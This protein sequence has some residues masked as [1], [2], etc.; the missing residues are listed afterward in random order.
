VKNSKHVW[1]GRGLLSRSAVIAV[2]LLAGAVA[3]AQQTTG[4]PCSPAATTTVDGK[5]LPS[6]SPEFG[7]AVNMSY[8]DSKSCWPATVVPPKGAPNILLI[9]TDDQ[10]YGVSSTFG[11]V[12]PTPALDRVAK[13]GLRYTQFHSTA[14]CSPTR[15]ALITGRNHHSVGFGVITEMSTGYPGYDSIIGPESATVAEILKE[16]GY[17]TSWFGKNHNTP[18]MQYSVAGP[19]NQWPSGMGFD[20]FYGFMGGETD[21]WTPWLFQNTTQIFPWVGHPGYNLITDMA[22]EAIKYLKGLNDAAPDKPFFL[23]YVPGGSHAPHQPTPEWIKKISDMHLFNKGWNDVREQILANQKRLGVVPANTQL[24]PWPDG[25]PEFGGAKLAKWETLSPDEKKLFIRQA[26]IFAAYT[27][28]TDHEIGRVIQA[29]DDMG[30]LDNTLIIYIV[31]DNGTSAEG[32]TLGTPFDMAAIQG[33]NIPVADQLKYYD[34]WGSPKT[35]PHMAVGWTWAFDTPFKWT[36]QVASHFG[37]TRQGLAISWP[38][39]ITDVG[40]LRTQFHHVIDIVPTLLEA[41]GIQAPVM[42]NGIAQKP[43]EGVTMAYTFDKANANAP[44]KRTTQYFEMVGNRAIYH[45]GWIAATTPPLAPWFLGLGKFPEVVNG[46]TWEL[47]NLDEDY[48][49][50]NDLAA[51]MPDKLLVMKELF[52]LEAEKYNV[53]PLDNSFT[54]R[55]LAPRPSATAGKTVF[56]YS[57]E[58]SGLPPSDAP[59]I[60]NKSYTITA[61]V[62]IPAG[63]A[64]GML[65]TIGGRFGGYGLYLVKGKPV[66]TYVQLTAEKFR[67]EG[68]AALTPGKHTIAFD[69]KY[70][71]PGFGKGGNGVLSVD[72]KAVASKTIP[73]TIPFVMTI[74]ESFDVGMDTRSGVDDNDYQ[75]PFRFNGKLDKLTIKLIPPE[76]TAAE[77]DLLKRKTQEAINAAQ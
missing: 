4:V 42:V 63:V 48:S 70:D 41:A 73:F 56:T 54:A 17:A 20:Y 69:F 10:G 55:A 24:T 34:D 52:L 65:N 6:P 37:G 1:S 5:Y 75:P 53:F 26:D 50:N 35:T 13:A 71:G 33:I 40:G 57:G 23:C 72:G 19:Y 44:S 66:F 59:N 77:D 2:F 29:V 8:K 31:G 32:S 25:Q 64:E 28:Y 62:E 67:W 46:Y 12:I 3:H 21:Q 61:E 30:K 14:L 39:H 27:A 38:G 76:R 18:S 16:N 7:G 49:E 22:D 15:A 58:S 51:K 68:S 60:L 36:K 11:G 9:M 43:I 74:D 45:D 47:Y